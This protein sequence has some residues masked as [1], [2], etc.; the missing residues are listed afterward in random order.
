MAD[1][2]TTNYP[3]T[4]KVLVRS[5][6]QGRTAL[7]IFQAYCLIHPEAKIEDLNRAFPR[8]K[9]ASTKKTRL[10]SSVSSYQP[11]RGSSFFP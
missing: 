5:E 10:I 3:A 9:F 8:E 7:G 6:N 11:A 1:I 4:A 2:Q